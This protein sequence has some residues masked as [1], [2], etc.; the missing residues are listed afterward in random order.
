MGRSA[1]LGSRTMYRYEFRLRISAEEYLDYYRGV[2]Q[3]VI[4]RSASGLTVQFPASLLRRFVTNEGVH[5]DFLLTCD[6][7]HKCLDL[8]RLDGTG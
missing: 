4:V 6:A 3:H 7:N 1:I 2:V 5:G 8:Q